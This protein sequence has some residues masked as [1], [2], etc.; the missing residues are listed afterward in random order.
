MKDKYKPYFELEKE[1]IRLKIERLEM[2]HTAEKFLIA[3]FVAL[4]VDLLSKLPF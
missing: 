4:L 2:L 3:L 1:N